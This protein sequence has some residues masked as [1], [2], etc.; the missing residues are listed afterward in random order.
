MRKIQIIFGAFILGALTASTAHAGTISGKVD[1]TGTAP[2]QEKI[3]MAA[4]PS[5]AAMGGDVMTE[6]VVVNADGTLSNVFIYIKEGLEGQQFS[7]PKE[8]VPM[9]QRGCHYI[10]HVFGVQVNQPI[11]IINSDSTLHNVH[12]LPTKSKQ[13][14][15]GMPIKGMKLKKKFG[16]PEVMVKIKCDVHPWMHAYVGVLEH[17]FFSVTQD[18]GTFEITDLPAGTYMVEAWHEKFGTQTQE[19]TVDEAG[20]QSINFSFAG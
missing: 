20:V 16:K 14:N 4:D 6:D 9:D 11:E 5:C 3:N 19:V 7:T 2:A 18:A 13:F 15:L 10:P 12:S 17:P 8:A 1:F